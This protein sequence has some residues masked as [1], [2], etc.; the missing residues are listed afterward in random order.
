MPPH[1]PDV[2]AVFGA[3]PEVAAYAMAKYSRSALSLRESLRE[4][5]EQKAEKFLDTFYFQYG[6]RSIADLAHVSLAVERL[7]IL[8]AIE[9]ADESKWDGQERS[10]RYQEFG[11][12]VEAGLAWRRPPELPAQSGY[13]A[14]MRELFA[15]YEVVSARVHAY[16]RSVVPRPE[17]MKP[18]TYDRT[19]RARAFDAGRYLLPLGTTTSLGQ[20]VS[21]RVLEQ[22]IARLLSSPY[23][24]SRAVG[25]TLRAA[26][27]T[28]AHDPRR[29][30]L[31]RLAEFV[32]SQTAQPGAAEALAAVE[33]LA[34]P[35]RVAPTLVKYAEAS[36]YRIETRRELAEA[37][38]EVLATAMP[39]SQP[40]VTLLEPEPLDVEVAATLLYGASHHSYRQTAAAVAALPAARRAEIISIGWRHRGPHDELLRE[41]Q[42]GQALRFDI[43]MDV[44]GYRDL[45]R[46]RRCV[47]VAQ[48]FTWMHGYAAPPVLAEC[49]V[50]PVYGAA[51]EQVRQQAEAIEGQSREA[52]V[53]LMPLAFRRRCL[54][55]MDLAEANYI[56]EQRTAPAGHGSYREAAWAM[57]EA[58]RQRHPS[59]ARAWRVT[60]LEPAPDLLRR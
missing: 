4:I 7:S 35:V 8:A 40:G 3:E 32:R 15:A 21:A 53:Y 10:T 51:L 30:D 6:H 1:D 42:A 36:A 49:G 25:E 39:E 56:A 38:R 24:E 29:D 58:V 52:A 33:R 46:H 60:P 34:R 44:G 14:A 48:E 41:Y 26:A 20:I 27:S 28:P 23:A 17:T 45:H 31:E 11:A 55:K 9:V 12:G 18:E 47:Q 43:L 37:A 16:Y 54:F 19:L 5:S 59:L 57:Y 50:E 2:Y 22:Q 13:D